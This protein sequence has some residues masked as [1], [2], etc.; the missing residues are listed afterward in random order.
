[1]TKAWRYCLTKPAIT[2]CRAL[3]GL[4]FENRWLTI[5]KQGRFAFMRAMPGMAAVLRC[6]SQAR[7]YG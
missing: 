6:V 7:A 2:T 4:R 5:G 1:M 3:D